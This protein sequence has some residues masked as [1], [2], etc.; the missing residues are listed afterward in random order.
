MRLFEIQNRPPLPVSGQKP[1]WV[2]VLAPMTAE[3]WSDGWSWTE[4][5]CFA[6]A[7][8]MQKAYGGQQWCVA[9]FDP[10][11][12]DW[13]AEHA[14]VKIGGVYYEFHGV[15]DPQTYVAMLTRK[16]KKASKGPYQRE[17]KR[18]GSP[19]LFWFEDEN[20]DDTQW[21]QLLMVLKTGKLT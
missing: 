13:A 4:G 20:L 14:V 1:W 10:E 21:K 7:D 8:R 3:L 18:K 15:F 9:R 17:M 6:F 16:D 19:G 5:G 11:E 12:K 2:D